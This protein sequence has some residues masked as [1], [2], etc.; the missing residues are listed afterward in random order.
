MEKK[1]VLGGVVVAAVIGII[2]ILAVTF[3]VPSSVE[4][5]SI[6]NEKVGL[7]INTKSQQTTIQELSE[8]YRLATSAGIGRGNVYLFWNSIEPIEGQF[9]WKNSDVIMSLHKQNGLKVTLFFSVINGQTLGPFPRWMGNPDI[10]SLQEE[11]LVNVLDAI[12]SRYDIIDTVI[13]SG[14]TEEYFRFK[15][16]FIPEYKDFF[17][18]THEKIQQKYPDVKFGNSFSLNN[19]IN[20][21]LEDTVK[22]LNVGDFIAYSYFP[23]DSLNEIIKTPKEARNDLNYGLEL[24]SELNVGFFEVGWSTSESVG[25]NETNQEEFIHESLDFYDEN[26][27]KI[28]FMTW[29]RLYD[30]IE[31]SCQISVDNDNPISVGGGSGL[32]TNEFVIERL[33]NYLCDAGLVKSNEQVKPG[34]NSFISKIKEIES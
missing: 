5:T 4:P 17:Q 22:E 12:L 29:F 27:S 15:E 11:K 32:G 10:D 18:R 6:R 2:A 33:E 3:F 23:T 26:K 14:Q 20:K 19:V 13:F 25:G 28:D 8:S 1:L 16:S 34:W 9:D 24:A 7:V 31:D 30:R 21:N